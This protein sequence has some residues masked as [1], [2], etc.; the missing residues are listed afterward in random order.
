MTE[1]EER[2]L[3]GGGCTPPPAPALPPESSPRLNGLNKTV[4][5]LREGEDPHQP[6]FSSPVWMEEIQ[7]RRIL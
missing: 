1:K 7:A 6:K 5:G 2:E 3:N 4:R